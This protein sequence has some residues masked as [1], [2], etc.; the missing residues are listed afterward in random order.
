M[1]RFSY[2]ARDGAG[3]TSSGVVMA[4]SAEEAAGQLRAEGKYIIGI[5]PAGEV[6][7]DETTASRLRRVKRKEVIFFTHQMAVMIET[8]V[9]LTDALECAMDQSNDV[10]FKAVLEEV[11]KHV[12]GGGEFS[13]ALEQFPL[14]FP[15]AMTSL[16]RASEVSG[17]MAPMLNRLAGYLAKE[18]STIRQARGAMMYPMFMAVMAIAVTIFLLTFV[19]PKFAGI[20]ASRAA[21]LPGPTRMLM[22]LSGG[23][24]DW[25]YV[26]VSLA[27]ALAVT[28]FTLRRVHTGKC[29]FDW[30]KL[31]LPIA[32]NLY[33]EL[34]VTRACRTMGTLISAGVSMLEMIPI[35]KQVTNNIYFDR[36]WD[37]VDE[38]LRQG[39]QLSAPLFASTLFPRTVVQM[40]YAGE[41]S[42]QLGTVLGRV[43]DFTE[44]EF[45]QTVKTTTQFIEPLM[46][47]VMGGVIG[48][49]AI[50]LLLP[51]FN[52]GNVVSGGG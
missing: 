12:K 2:Q 45:D 41:K 20:Y 25:W 39:D 13:V 3:A 35:I 18:D 4:T 51:I 44:G 34:Y 42:G 38:R 15:P 27:V 37:D 11:S 30:L 9:P 28:V 49:V 36:L 16:V 7:E 52:V 6:E 40:I 29:V 47:A 14:A 8:G 17:T 23:L 46:V 50:S 26:W 10:H 32:R 33:G 5:T 1:A 19:L 21:T 22:A 24:I 48:F 43:A 31:N